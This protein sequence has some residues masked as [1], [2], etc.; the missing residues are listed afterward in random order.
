V[1]PFDVGSVRI[2]PSKHFR[3]SKMRKWG[4]SVADLRLALQEP[5]KVVRVGK[6][7]VEIWV[8]RDVSKKLVIGHEPGEAFIVVITGTE[9]K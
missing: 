3:I 8:R 2:E 6:R 1:L 4:W 5:I 7:K 9:G